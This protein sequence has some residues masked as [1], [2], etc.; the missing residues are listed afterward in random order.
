MLIQPFFKLQV[1]WYDRVI[2]EWHEKIEDRHDT[3][4]YDCTSTNHIEVCTSV[5]P[6]KVT[7][8]P[9]QE[10]D[11]GNFMSPRKYESGQRGSGS[12]EH[13]YECSP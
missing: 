13:T 12:G 2:S 9:G 6:F 4:K 3:N 5:H 7:C 11:T 8:M 10:R 1:L